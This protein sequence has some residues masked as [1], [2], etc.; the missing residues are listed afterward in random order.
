MDDAGNLYVSSDNTGVD[1]WA[2][3]SSTPTLA[4]HFCLVDQ[5]AG[6]ATNATAQTF[7]AV[8]PRLK[9]KKHLP[10]IVQ[11]NPSSEDCPKSID[12][13]QTSPEFDLAESLVEFGGNLFLQVVWDSEDGIFELPETGSNPRIPTVILTGIRP[14]SGNLAVGP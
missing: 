1:V 3:P 6:V 7:V 8:V 2:T 11:F 5:A 12:S 10:G 14:Y 4:R 13:F 9:P